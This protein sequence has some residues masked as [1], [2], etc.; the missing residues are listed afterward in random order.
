MHMKPKALVKNIGKDRCT[1][2]ALALSGTVLSRYNLANNVT[3]LEYNPI[4]PHFFTASI[5]L[6]RNLSKFTCWILVES[7]LVKLEKLKLKYKTSLDSNFEP[8]NSD[9]LKPSNYSSN[10]T[11][12]Y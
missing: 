1:I 7:Y 9:Y 5:Q 6:L 4:L 10:I 12:E 8:K 11:L 3:K 2:F